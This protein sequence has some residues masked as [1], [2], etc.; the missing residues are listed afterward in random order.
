MVEL[1]RREYADLYGPTTGDRVRLADTDLLVEI[2]RDLSGGPGRAGDEAVFG[3]G[4][5]IRESMGQSRATRAE[6]TPDTVITGAVVLDHTGIFKADVGIRDGRITA[7][8]KA[9]NPDTMDG[10]HPE[11][12][13]GPETEVI[14]GNGRILTAGG[15]DA[16]VHFIAPGIA[17]EALA[18]GVT[19]LVGGGTGPAE[20]SKATTVTPG[21]WHLERMLAALDDLPLNIG[22]LG[23]GN[24]VSADAMRAQLR[25]GAVGFKIHEDWGA[26]PAVIDACLTVCAETGAQLA[27]HTDTL[28]EAGFVGDTLAAIAGRTIHAYHTEGAGGGHAPDIIT[29]VAEP[30]VL[31]SSTNPTRPHTVNTVEEHLD[32]LMVCHHL[33]PAVPEDLAFAESRIR[34]STIAAEDVLHDLGAISIISSDSQAM[35]RVGEVVLRTW[36]TAHVMKRRRGPLPGDG[37][38]DN[39]RARRYVAK[40]TINPAIAQGMDREIGSVEPGK[41]A[42]LVLW[43]PAFFGVKPLLVL[44]GG[45]LAYA[46]MG[47]ANASIPTPQP[48]LARPMFGALGR[49]PAANSVNFVTPLALADGLDRRLAERLG[50]AKPLVAIRDTRSLTKADMRLNDARPAVTVDP[51]SFTVTIDGEP[52]VPEPATELPMAQRYFLF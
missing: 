21:S 9:G 32:M 30:H 5:V 38:A 1:S 11:L 36:Q 19:T 34:P 44:K 43:E 45:Q 23:K 13:I 41:L 27:I 10:V 33:N 51:D 50:V 16:H 42:D 40:Y 47:D 48:Q 49:A 29:V 15:V 24:T 2:E 4:K 8:G 46:Q 6:G 17:H 39:Q 35:G 22:L 3:G 26:T 37:P 14:A 52:V 18:S 20:G 25:G 28:N 12:V 31:P 7:L